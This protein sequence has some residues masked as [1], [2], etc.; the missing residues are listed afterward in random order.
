MLWHSKQQTSGIHDSSKE[1]GGISYS[2]LKHETTGT[3]DYALTEEKFVKAERLID[4]DL[5]DDKRREAQST[6]NE[7]GIGELNPFAQGFDTTSPLL[8]HDIFQI[9]QTAQEEL[10]FIQNMQQRKGGLSQDASQFALENR[11]QKLPKSFLD[12][13]L[14]YPDAYDNYPFG[15]FALSRKRKAAEPNPSYLSSIRKQDAAQTAVP[16][17]F[18]DIYML[19]QQDQSESLNFTH[20]SWNNESMLKMLNL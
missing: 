3:T 6:K 13:N 8:Y 7:F 17:E 9:D 18:D 19:N 20:T 2:T 14:Y 16:F 11:A 12:S 1:P 15:D 5:S 4:E 10:T